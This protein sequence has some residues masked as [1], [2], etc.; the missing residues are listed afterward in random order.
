MLKSGLFEGDKLIERDKC[1]KV[2]KS[3]SIMKKKKL[4]KSLIFKFELIRP[5]FCIIIY[6]YMHL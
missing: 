4:V 5:T 2:I 1:W 6:L 3:G